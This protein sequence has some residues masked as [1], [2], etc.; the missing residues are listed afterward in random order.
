MLGSCW[1]PKGPK[2]D[3]ICFTCLAIRGTT[4]FMSRGPPTGLP[5]SA[6]GSRDAAGAEEG[7][8]GQLIQVSCLSWW[9]FFVYGLAC[10]VPSLLRLCEMSLIDPSLGC[11]EANPN[12]LSGLAL[13]CIW[14]PGLQILRLQR[15]ARQGLHLKL[16]VFER[17]SSAMRMSSSAVM[18]HIHEPAGNFRG[19]R[20]QSTL[21]RC[22]HA[23]PVPDSITTQ[24]ATRTHVNGL[25]PQAKTELLL[26]A[27]T[28][29]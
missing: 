20:A 3:S 26:R 7:G 16:G 19:I 9:S 27:F 18:R 14:S 15:H 25:G 23:H 12:S 6:W 28:M 10:I 24:R 5:T 2:A 17:V 8:G 4:M 11:S 29:L 1:A 21:Q 22:V 13:R